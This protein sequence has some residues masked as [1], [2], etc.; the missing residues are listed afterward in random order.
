MEMQ[1]G[2]GRCPQKLKTTA[3]IALAPQYLV[4]GCAVPRR[5]K[6]ILTYSQMLTGRTRYLNCGIRIVSSCFCTDVLYAAGGRRRGFWRNTEVEPRFSQ[7][8]PLCR[9]R[10][11][12]GWGSA[13]PLSARR[14]PPRGFR[15]T[16]I[17][18][19]SKS[20]S[21]KRELGMNMQLR[22]PAFVDRVR[23]VGHFPG[24]FGV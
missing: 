9:N 4:P 23:P 11:S 3:S 14:G 19:K 15:R 24:P 22:W 7:A 17:L 18:R 6:G 10:G 12:D 5:R 21:S 2:A 13:F 16:I 1:E 8:H 20:L